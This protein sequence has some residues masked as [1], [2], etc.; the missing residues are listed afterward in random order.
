MS[1]QMT[2]CARTACR[3]ACLRAYTCGCNPGDIQF[4]VPE[5]LGWCLSSGGSCHGWALFSKGGPQGVVVGSIHPQHT[6]CAS[7]AL[8]VTQQSHSCQARRYGSALLFS[9][10]E[11]IGVQACFHVADQAM[12]SC[13]KTRLE[14]GKTPLSGIGREGLPPS[15]P[16]STAST[17]ASRSAMPPL[18][19]L[20]RNAP[21]FILPSISLLNM[22]LCNDTSQHLH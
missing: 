12:W 21:F 17:T 13:A 2:Y 8:L 5:H 22:F 10:G 11:N 4:S 16:D 1:K 18:A 9:K 14:Q 6:L 19:V 15:C 20:I 7:Q 3:S